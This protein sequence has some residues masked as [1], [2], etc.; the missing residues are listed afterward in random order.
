MKKMNVK[1]WLLFSQCLRQAPCPGE[2]VQGV[3]DCGPNLAHEVTA[4]RTHI[5]WHFIFF[6]IIKKMYAI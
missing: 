1:E 6:S 5:Q 4:L 3:L 2:P